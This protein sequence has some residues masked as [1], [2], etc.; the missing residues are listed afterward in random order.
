MQRNYK[1]INKAVDDL[2]KHY[3]VQFDLIIGG[4]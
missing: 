3:I 1:K 2:K 4:F